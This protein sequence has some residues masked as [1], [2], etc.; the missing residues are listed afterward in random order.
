M[1]FANAEEMYK[2]FDQVLEKVKKDEALYKTLSDSASV[3][4]MKVPNLDATFTLE[5]KGSIKTTYGLCDIKPDAT[6]IQNDEIF[7]K[8]W[9][10]KLNLMIAMTKGQVKASGAMTK[11][12]K[13]LPKINP[14]YKYYVEVLNEIGRVDLVVK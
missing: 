9:Q 14:I 3:L 7:N 8:F 1:A 10:G 6:T 2:L 12:L 4:V 13:L 5:M 11:M